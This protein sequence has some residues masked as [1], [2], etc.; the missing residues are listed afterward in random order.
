[1][2]VVTG[3]SR[4]LGA[5]MVRALLARGRNV[6][7][8]SRS[9]AV[10]AGLE[11]DWLPRLHAMACDVT[12]E[13]RLAACLGQLDAAV[14]GGIRVL[15]NN[16]GVH[17]AD[18]ST[19]LALA[20]FDALLRT[21]AGACFAAARLV[22]PYLRRQGGVI[23]NI[24]SVMET[25]GAARNVAYSASKGAVGAMTRA[26]ASEWARDRIAVLDLAPGYVATDM[27]TGYLERE[28]VRDYFA[29]Q[30]LLGRPARPEE[31]G[32]LVAGLLAMDLMLLTGQTLRADGGHS[33]AHGHIR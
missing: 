11:P 17:R 26:L 29:R 16:A 9:G 30:T 7:A 6:G 14:E 23:L 27:N 20:D 25:L 33:V 31:I 12:D 2:V 5:A 13:T 19:R 4:G 21:N 28:D 8:L 1:M 24:G 15:I 22:H 18:T 10:P 3:A 32:E